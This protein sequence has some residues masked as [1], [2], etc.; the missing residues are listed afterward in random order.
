MDNGLHE[1][2]S[3]EEYHSGSGISRSS[4]MLI[5]ESPFH[6]KN[7]HT[8]TFK[9]SD[10]KTIGSMVHGLILEPHLFDDEF[11]LEPIV[12]KRTKAGRAE[13]DE[14]KEDNKEKITYSESM[15]NQA[16]DMT[17]SF[18]NFESNKN[19]FKDIDAEQ[20]IFWI[21]EETGLQFKCRPDGWIKSSNIIIDL[22]TTKSAKLRQ[23]Q[24]SCLDY[25]YLIQAAMIKEG[26]ASLGVDMK[27]YLIA[28]IE[29]TP[30]Y[31]SAIY[32][33]DEDA[34]NYGLNQFNKAAR[35]LSDCMLKDKWPSYEPDLLTIPNYLKENEE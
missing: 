22:K 4:L 30:P 35:L 24:R 26:L 15:L 8:V 13:I 6:Y 16:T 29:K 19:L 28:A 27:Q 5:L 12:N 11:A 9:D 10:A 1:N 7:R 34:I 3:I 33:I 23:M 18:F 20:S 17:E 32:M 14:F 25:G 2:I 21:H 31:A